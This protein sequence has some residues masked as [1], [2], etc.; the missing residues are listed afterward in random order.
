MLPTT[1]ASM[2]A[3][4]KTPASRMSRPQRAPIVSPA[5]A[6]RH[7][8]SRLCPI[9]YQWRTLGQY[10]ADTPACGSCMPP[11]TARA[12]TRAHRAPRAVQEDLQWL[13]D[14]RAARDEIPARLGFPTLGSLQR[15][16]YRH[17][18]ADLVDRITRAAAA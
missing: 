8:H 3:R 12:A 13:L 5:K 15:W 17:D 1:L 14:T 10:P 2:P 6:A 16:L 7:P 18:R 9:C 4:G 11:A